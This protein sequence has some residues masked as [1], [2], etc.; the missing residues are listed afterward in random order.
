MSPRPAGGG[1]IQS[2][3]SV[4]ALASDYHSPR[5]P[6]RLESPTDVG[7][8]PTGRARR[9]EPFPRCMFCVRTLLLRMRACPQPGILTFIVLQW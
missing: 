6:F 5:S 4:L 9:G 8:V 1:A 2:H 7:M 3:Q